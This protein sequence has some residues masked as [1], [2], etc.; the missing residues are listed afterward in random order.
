MKVVIVESP[1][2]AKTINKYLGSDYF[3]LASYGHIRDLPSKNG[4]VDPKNN[5]AMV[6]E[7]EER[8]KKNIQDILKAAKKADALFLAT[9]PDREGEAISWHVRE[10]LKQN[11]VATNIDVKRIVF[12]EVTKK[13]VQEA[14]K[15]PRELNQKLVDAYLAR[16]AL[17]YLVGFTLSPVLWTKL[18][19]SR[20]AGRVQSVA[21]RMVAE[22]EAEIEAF[23]TDEYWSIVGLFQAQTDKKVNAKLTHFVG[24]KLDKLAIKNQ[25]QAQEIVKE[26]AQQSYK[27]LDIDKKQVKRHPTAP[28]ITS[29]L[30]QEASRKL[31]FGARKTMQVAQQLYEGIDVQGETIG[32]ITYMRTDSVIIAAEAITS[33][34]EFITQNYG[35]PYL[36]TSPRV[37]KSKAKN[38]QEAHEAIRPTDVALVPEK[39]RKFLE[40]DQWALYDLIWKRTM[41]SQMESAIFEQVSIDIGTANKQIIFRAT[42][43]TLLFDGFLKL[44]EEG[45]DEDKDDENRLLPS[46]S[47]NEVLNLDTIT[48]HQHFTQPPPHYTEASLVKKMEELGIGRPSTYAS[49]MSTLIDRNYVRFEKRQLVSETRGRLVTSF[50]KEYFMKYVEYDFTADLEEQLDKISNGDLKWHDVMAQFWQAF[51]DQVAQTKE[52]KISDVITMLDK[53]LESFIFGTETVEPDRKC[54]HCSSGTLSLKL[55]KFGAFIGCSDY[56][57]CNYT[58]QIV[59]NSDDDDNAATKAA[60]DVTDPIEIGLD[61]KSQD[62]ITLRKGPYGFYLQWGE[63]DKVEGKKKIKP[64]RV[65]LPKDLAPNSVTLEKALSLGALPRVIGRDPDNGDKI[66]GAIGRFG[67]YVKRG[68]T[69]ASLTKDDDIYTVTLSRSLEL[70]EIA[71]EKANKKAFAGKSTAEDGDDNKK[72][73]GKFVKKTMAPKKISGAKVKTKN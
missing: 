11:N 72:T 64:K 70:F 15:S 6:W 4:S 40:P 27:I 28:F 2:K 68:S 36:P 59:T 61:P 1:A 45:L 69:F 16:R 53:N 51:S 13:A 25:Q 35:K 62:M 33:S 56:P 52:L 14:L 55:G 31:R 73:K 19:G 42:G 20:S 63:G 54:P 18:P 48:P 22:R 8:S 65:S 46:F 38:A 57:D 3:V 30:Q 24:K 49:V 32:L 17:D 44:Y 60:I 23:K 71:K 5:F 47:P 12:Y 21:L 26:T 41:A 7:S 67:P 37:Y 34:R 9:D 66:T 50:L 58:R 29:T 10:V 43:S 39:L